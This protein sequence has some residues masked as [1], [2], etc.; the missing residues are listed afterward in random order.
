MDHAHIL[1]ACLA[2]RTHRPLAHIREDTE[3]DRLALDSLALV[4]LLVELE[5]KHGLRLALGDLANAR[6]VGDLA[7]RLAA[8]GH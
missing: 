1:K 2:R 3:L 8:S 6:T 4:E 7:A 5:H